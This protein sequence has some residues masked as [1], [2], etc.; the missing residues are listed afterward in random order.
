MLHVDIKSTKQLH[1]IGKRAGSRPRQ[2]IVPVNDFN[3]KTTVL[4]NCYKLKG[5]QLSISEDFI[6]A[7]QS[8][9][10]KSAL[11]NRENSN[12]VTLFFLIR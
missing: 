9:L 3:E 6:Q 8:D 1:R 7:I 10:W 4:K 12:K 5:T 11:A 2:V